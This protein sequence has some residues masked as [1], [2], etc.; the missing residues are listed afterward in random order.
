[1]K[2]LVPEYTFDPKTESGLD[3]WTEAVQK[4]VDDYDNRVIQHLSFADCLKEV[5]ELTI[6]Q[7]KHTVLGLK[8][9]DRI[10]AQIDRHLNRNRE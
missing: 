9:L 3:A 8:V 10:V 5:S 7:D 1:M 2:H 4:Y 6:E